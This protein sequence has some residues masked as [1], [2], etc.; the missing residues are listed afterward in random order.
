MLSVRGLRVTYGQIEAVK[1]LDLDVH[2]GEIVALIG[3]NGAGKTTTLMTI[4]GALRPSAGT[5]EFLGR[6]INGQ[7][8]S[9]ILRLGL[10]HVPEGRRIF[11]RFTVL[12]NLEAGAIARTDRRAITASI[13]AV[14]TSFPVLRER[15]AQ[16][17]GTLSGGEQQMLAI[18]RALMAEPK[19]LLLDEPS[20]GLAP[21]M[22]ERI[23]G[24][25]R[26]IHRGGTTL[27]LVEQN[28][29]MA[30]N[31]ADRAYVLE[32]GRMAVHGPSAKLRDDPQVQASYLGELTG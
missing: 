17:G 32:T 1:G 16:L 23:F 30:L 31:L 8:A 12:E 14:F 18:G 11:K 20:L 25:I 24:M 27:L 13:E 29:R 5:I 10:A 3:G 28:A 2:E 4:S 7:P 9:E 21:L 19:L 6:R 26:S 22:V 15:R